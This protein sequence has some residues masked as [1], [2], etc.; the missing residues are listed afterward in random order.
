MLVRVDRE[1][2]NA[3]DVAHQRLKAGSLES[4]PFLFPHGP[5]TAVPALNPCFSSKYRAAA[6]PRLVPLMD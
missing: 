1:P 2:W 6:F 5:S 3:G 4:G